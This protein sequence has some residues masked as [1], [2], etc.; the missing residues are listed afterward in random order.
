MGPHEVRDSIA[1]PQGF[2]LYLVLCQ[3][4]VCC[5]QLLPIHFHI[6]MGVSYT[7]EVATTLEGMLFLFPL[8][9]RQSPPHSK[10][11]F[12]LFLDTHS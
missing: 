2:T 4:S 11:Q 10:S 8:P 1:L 5:L 12:Q 9:L 6:V 7:L 3:C